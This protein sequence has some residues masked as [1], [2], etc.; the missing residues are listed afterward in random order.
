MRGSP[1]SIRTA[2]VTAAICAVALGGGCAVPQLEVTVDPS[3]AMVFVDSTQAH[4]SEAGRTTLPLSYYG[5][6]S[7]SGRQTKGDDDEFISLFDETRRVTV[8]E[9]FSPWLFPLDFFLEIAAYPF[10]DSDYTHAVHIELSE[11]P[12]I[13][14]R[15]SAADLQEIRSR[16]RRALLD[17]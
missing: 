15:V 16:A 2:A 5:T 3:D 9:P 12:P 4:R 17:R 1:A 10:Q 14:D 13:V 7:V 6:T 11:R 8:N